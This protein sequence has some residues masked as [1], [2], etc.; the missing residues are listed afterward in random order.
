MIL[1]YLATNPVGISGDS[2][3]PTKGNGNR[4][5]GMDPRAVVQYDDV[6][7][8][9]SRHGALPWAQLFPPAIKLARHGFRTT[10]YLYEKLVVGTQLTL[11]EGESFMVLTL[12]YI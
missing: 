11:C 12:F 10:Q 8:F 6:N 9:G 2:N 1:T 4:L 7:I 3:W 5:K